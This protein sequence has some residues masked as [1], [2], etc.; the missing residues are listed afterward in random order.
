MLLLPVVLLIMQRGVIVREETYWSNGSGLSTES[1]E[2][3]YDG[4][5]ETSPP[6]ERCAAT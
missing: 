2:S 3:G 1:I 5:S 6:L 4:G